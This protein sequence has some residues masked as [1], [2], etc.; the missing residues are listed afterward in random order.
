[1]SNETMREYYLAQIRSYQM[2]IMNVEKEIRL[3]EVGLANL[4]ESLADAERKLEELK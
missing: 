4:K 3:R 2:R 1:M